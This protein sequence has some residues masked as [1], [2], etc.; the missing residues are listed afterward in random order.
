MGKS[1][2]AGID[3]IMVTIDEISVTVARA[4]KMKPLLPCESLKVA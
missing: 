3:A 4:G 2:R 1:G